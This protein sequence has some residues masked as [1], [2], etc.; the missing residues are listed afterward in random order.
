MEQKIAFIT[1]TSKGLGESIT[2]LLLKKKYIVYGYSRTNTI[3]NPNFF[4][5]KTNLFDFKELK[6]IKFPE[7]KKK[8]PPP[9]ILLINKL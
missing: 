8:D 6:K 7:I 4:F 3:K 1:G 9:K 5:Q 2:K